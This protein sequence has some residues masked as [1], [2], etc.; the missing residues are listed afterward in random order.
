MTWIVG[1]FTTP[2][3]QMTAAQDLTVGALLM[4]IIL[5]FI[6]WANR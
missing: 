6:L 1:C 3:L 2:Q 4:A 5:P